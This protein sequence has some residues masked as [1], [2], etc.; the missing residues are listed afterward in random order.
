M[1]VHVLT[2]VTEP[3]GLGAGSHS[4]ICLPLQ[5]SSQAELRLGMAVGLG[6]GLRMGL[7][8]FSHGPQPVDG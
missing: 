6:F 7:G 8:D 5:C 4:I 2:G 1:S 3:W